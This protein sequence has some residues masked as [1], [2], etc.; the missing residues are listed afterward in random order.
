[1]HH[2]LS[3]CNVAPK[4]L[5]DYV[6][7]DIIRYGTRVQDLRVKLDYAFG[8]LTRVL[9]TGNEAGEGSGE[10]VDLDKMRDE[11]VM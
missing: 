7:K 10:D 6:N 2:V 4:D 5:E 1:M 8:E 3:E 11:M 9:T